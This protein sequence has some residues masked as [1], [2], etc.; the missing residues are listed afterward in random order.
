MPLCQIAVNLTESAYL[1]E[2]IRNPRWIT[3]KVSERLIPGH[4]RREMV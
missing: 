1:K 3:D 2:V 4:Y